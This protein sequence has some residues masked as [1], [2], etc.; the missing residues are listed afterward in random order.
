MQEAQKVENKQSLQQAIVEEN[1]ENAPE[2]HEPQPLHQATAEDDTESTTEAPRRTPTVYLTARACSLQSHACALHQPPDIQLYTS[3]VRFPPAMTRSSRPPSPPFSAI[4][5]PLLSPPNSTT[6]NARKAW[7]PQAMDEWLHCNG[8]VMDMPMRHRCSSCHWQRINPTKSVSIRKSLGQCAIRF[9]FMDWDHVNP[10]VLF[11]SRF[12]YDMASA[13]LLPPR[14]RT[15]IV[16]T[17][18]FLIPFFAGIVTD[19]F[20]AGLVPANSYI[21]H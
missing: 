6:L 20:G 7:K 8:K 11:F 15:L 3:A 19:S 4:S 21:S 16:A 2:N 12:I 18:F 14:C 10:F 1:A 9:L 17:I 5:S 13:L